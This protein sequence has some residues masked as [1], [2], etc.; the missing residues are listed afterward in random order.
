M[1]GSQNVMILTKHNLLGGKF[2]KFVDLR[3][4]KMAV[5]EKGLCDLKTILHTEQLLPGF[6]AI[7]AGNIRPMQFCLVFRICVYS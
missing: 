3:L 5:L 1:F 7:E 4:L 6:L 2:S